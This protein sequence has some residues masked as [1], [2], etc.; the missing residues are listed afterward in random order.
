MAVTGQKVYSLIYTAHP[1]EKVVDKPV[2]HREHGIGQSVY[3]YPTYKIGQRG[4]GLND[5]PVRTGIDFR[6]KNGEDKGQYGSGPVDKGDTQGVRHNPDHFLPHYG[7]LERR[8]KVLKADK[9]ATQKIPAYTV[10]K[11][12]VTPSEEGKIRKNKG[13]QKKRNTKKE[14]ILAFLAPA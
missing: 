12:G 14:K 4:N 6:Q 11:K 10:I 5:P 8:K 2:V 1:L 3:Q 13:S 9:F 7:I